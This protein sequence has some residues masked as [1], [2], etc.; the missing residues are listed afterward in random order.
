MHVYEVRPRKNKRG[1]D[2]ISDVLPFGRLWYQQ[3]I[4]N[5]EGNWVRLSFAG[6]LRHAVIRLRRQQSN[7]SLVLTFVASVCHCASYACSVSEAWR[8]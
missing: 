2:L 1:V 6:C 8:L 3:A 5:R 4:S 7:A